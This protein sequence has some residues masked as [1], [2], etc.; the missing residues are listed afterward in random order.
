MN[1]TKICTVGVAMGDAAGIGAEIVAKAAAEGV[2]SENVR[3]VVVGD[4]RQFERGAQIAG[5][6]CDYSVAHSVEEALLKDGLILLDTGKLDAFSV[7]PGKEDVN[8]GR[9]A[10]ENIRACVDYCRRGL[11]DAMSFA[12]NN[13]TTLKKAGFQ[14]H[15][16]IDLLAGFFDCRDYCGELGVLGQIWTSRVTSHIPLRDVGPALTGE[17]IVKAVELLERTMRAAGFQRPRIAVAGFNPHNGEGATCGKEEVEV[18]APAVSVCRGNGWD[19]TGPLSAD[20]LFFR[21]FRGDF[22]GAVSMYHDQGQIAMKLKGFEKGVTVM[23]GL[24]KPVTTCSHGSAFDIAGKGIAQSGA[25]EHAFLMAKQMATAAKK[26][27]GGS[28]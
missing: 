14:L 28:V 11:F 16:A 2:L 4:R 17:K 13:K 1:Q 20:T 21:L 26:S 22:D 18:I 10:G 6:S 23:A 3:T 5:A 19:I 7:E 12:P 27:G 9:D 24:P 25:W 15:G 8:C